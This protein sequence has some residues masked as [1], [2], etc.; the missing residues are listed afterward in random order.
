MCLMGNHYQ[1]HKLENGPLFLSSLTHEIFS[2]A[3]QNS[4][5]KEISSCFNYVPSFMEMSSHL[6]KKRFYAKGTDEK[7]ENLY[8]SQFLLARYKKYHLEYVNI[9]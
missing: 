6:H 8:V 9:C 7:T 5:S 3:L 2:T 4:A 1:W